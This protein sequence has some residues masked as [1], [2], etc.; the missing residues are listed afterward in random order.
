MTPVRALASPWAWQATFHVV[1]GMFL[2]VTTGAVICSA[3][4]LWWAA[5][6]SLAEGPTGS[7]MLRVLYVVVAVVVPLAVPSCVRFFS[8]LQRE[9]FRALL[10]VDIA[11]PKY[12][13]GTGWRRSVRLWT[14]SGM[15]RQLVY[16]LLAPL[17]GGLGGVAVVLCWAAPL[18]AALWSESMSGPRG[19]LAFGGATVL[20]FAAPWLAR[21]VAAA[22]TAAARR[23]LGRDHAEELAE[24]VESLARSRADLVAAEDTQRR[25]IER[26]LH[27]GV[28]QRLVSLALNLGMARAASTDR[29]P[30][31]AAVI[32]AAHEDATAALAELRDF[33]RG[34]HPAVLNDRGLDAAL[35]GVAA[36]ASL[37]VQLNVHIGQRCS[38]SIEAIAYFAVSEALTNIA[39]H[40]EASRAEIAAQRVGDRLIIAVT[41]DGRGG[42]SVDSTGTGLQGLAQRA[43]AVDGRLT[44]VS[45]PGGPTTI[46]VDLPCE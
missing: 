1:A 40:A 30:Q 11:A 34:L 33:V 41:D 32:A 18:L 45:P 28:Q 26:D 29:S 38:P 10:G 15:W 8:A 37:P 44:V 22:D 6:L 25:R 24:R 7:W 27:D 17:L 46:T 9:R 20:L 16:H 36:R 43:A 4:V 3:A 35:S 13:P 2:S 5:V 19:L 12:G 23:L 31:D 14:A 42:A 21:G 39:K